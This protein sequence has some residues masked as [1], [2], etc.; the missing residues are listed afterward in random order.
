MSTEKRVA[1]RAV[2]Y[3][4]PEEDMVEFRVPGK[5]SDFVSFIK[6]A[7]EEIEGK[8]YAEVEVVDLKDKKA[9][10]VFG[11]DTPEDKRKRSVN[12]W[13]NRL[14]ISAKKLRISRKALRMAV[15]AA[16]LRVLGKGRDINYLLKVEDENGSIEYAISDMEDFE[17]IAPYLNKF[18]VQILW[19][20]PEELPEEFRKVYEGIRAD[21]RA[22][23]LRG[24]KFVEI[25]KEMLNK[26]W[27]EKL[28]KEGTSTENGKYLVMRDNKRVYA[29][30]KTKSGR[31]FVSS[32]FISE[33]DVIGYVR[34]LQ[35]RAG[36]AEEY[37]LR[38]DFYAK[39]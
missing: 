3:Y 33:K 23:V 12:Y 28:E 37:V 16:E 35:S 17:V 15:R 39:K 13:K 34:W 22:I 20:K 11:E 38:K 31:Y 6:K 32:G 5:A 21:L 18:S 2:I 8:D 7:L 25:P 30:I 1:Y 24:K 10:I 14:G 36:I 27:R 19:K 26:Y 9:Y 4:Y 29:I